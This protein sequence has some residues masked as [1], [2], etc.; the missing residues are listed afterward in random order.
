MLSLYLAIE[1]QIH[2]LTA[3]L[4]TTKYRNDRLAPKFNLCP[5]CCRRIKLSINQM[6]ILYAEFNT[7][8]LRLL[9]III[10]GLQSPSL[11]QWP[12]SAHLPHAE[13]AFFPWISSLVGRGRTGD[14][15]AAACPLGPGLDGNGL[16]D[17]I[18]C[19]CGWTAVGACWASC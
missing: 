4:K 12:T 19:C 3:D 10:S 9:N 8:S 6:P 15:C 11:C 13:V 5:L 16:C 17:L 14:P 2:I 7:W 18:C 1:N